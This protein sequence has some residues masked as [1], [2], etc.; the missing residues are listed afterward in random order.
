ME[1]IREYFDL[2]LKG[3]NILLREFSIV[4]Q[5]LVNRLNFVHQ[6]ELLFAKQN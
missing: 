3:E 2:L 6:V 1:T 4:Q 5:S